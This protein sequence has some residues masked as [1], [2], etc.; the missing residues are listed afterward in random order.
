MSNENSNETTPPVAGSPPVPAFHTEDF[1]SKYANNARFEATVYDLKI[2]FGESDLATGSEIIRQHT[3]I[4]I[5]W[6]L[7]RVMQFWLQLNFGV[8][9]VTVGKVAIPANQIPPPPQSQ[10]PEIASQPDAQKAKDIY[11]KLREEFIAGL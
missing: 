8:T 1:R 3:A 9:E 5:P 10:P 4:T 11:L 6:A 7:V 2:V